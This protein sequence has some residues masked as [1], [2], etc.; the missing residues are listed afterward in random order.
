MVQYFRNQSAAGVEKD[1]GLEGITWSLEGGC[2]NLRA[3]LPWGV[4][5]NLGGGPRLRGLPLVCET[6]SLVLTWG[7]PFPGGAVLTWGVDPY[8]RGIPWVRETVQLPQQF[9]R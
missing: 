3:A 7:R 5:S 2:H 4:L 8:N 6:L 1:L 9:S